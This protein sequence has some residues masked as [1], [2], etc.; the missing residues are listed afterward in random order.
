M[1]EVLTG[2]APMLGVGARTIAAV[3]QVECGLRSVSLRQT[4]VGDDG[5]AALGAVLGGS[6][7]PPL[8]QQGTHKQRYRISPEGP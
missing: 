4:H 3:L 1:K 5:A 2:A 8:N 7:Y 6:G